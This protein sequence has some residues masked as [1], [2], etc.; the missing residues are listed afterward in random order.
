VERILGG[1]TIRGGPQGE[2]D[3]AC[4]VD[5]LSALAPTFRCAKGGSTLRYLNAH[6]YRLL[7]VQI[8][9]NLRDIE[10]L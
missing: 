10:E 6:Q 7:V 1:R 3:W 9:Y 2:L 4:L 8:L 5:D